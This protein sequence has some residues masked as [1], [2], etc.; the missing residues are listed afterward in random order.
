MRRTP[1]PSGSSA[2]SIFRL[3]DSKYFRWWF[4]GAVG[5]ICAALYGSTLSFSF[6]FDDLLYLKDNPFFRD[7][8]SFAFPTH[9]VAFANQA[10]VLGLD[11]DLS[12]NLILRPVTYFTFY[13][14]YIAEG[15][16][17][18]GFRVVNIAIHCTNTILLF[19]LLSHLLQNSRKRHALSAASIH[20]IA[21]I[22]ALLFLVHPMQIESVTYVIQRFTSFATFWFLFTAYTWFRSWS[23]TSRKA[24]LGWRSGAVAGLLLG[25]LTKECLFTAPFML[26]LLDWLVAGTLL[27]T[28][29]R[30]AWPLF[31]C[32]PLIPILIVL[33]SWAQRN[34]NV[35]FGSA[36]RVANPFAPNEYQYHYALTQPQVILTYLRLLLV[37]VGLNVDPDYPISTSI[38]QWRV[39]FSGTAIVSL[40]AGAVIAYRK[41]LSDLRWSLGF[42]GVIWFFLT[43]SISSSVVP[44]P[45]LMAEHRAYLPSIGVFIVLVCFSDWIRVR[46]AKY[47]SLRFVTGIGL[48][49]WILLLGGATISRNRVW[50]SEIVLWSDAC[51]KSPY[52]GRPWLNLGTAYGEAGKLAE[53]AD[54]F[55]KVIELEPI[56]LIAYGNLV[57][58][59]NDRG[60]HRDAVVA[61]LA[62]IK[63][64]PAHLDY[65]LYHNLGTAFY[66][67]GDI[68]N[69]IACN[70][71]SVTS[72]PNYF[73]GH[74][75][76]AGLYLRTNQLELALKHYQLAAQLQSLD[77]TQQKICNQL[78]DIIRQLIRQRASKP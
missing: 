1:P 6:V 72:N 57:K 2:K 32:L 4:M 20:F 54:C 67:L 30:R 75:A 60:R 52:K 55:R 76:L 21:V 48:A 77:A 40:L 62:G 15:M 71:A 8:H 49:I 66:K 31:L 33:T 78:G 74:L 73:G 44:L 59:E 64:A 16:K 19:Q 50:R 51:S 63:F 43:L 23:A 5:V 47:A 7:L 65:L 35:D 25:M 10:K 34:G 53:A 38:L 17:P 68:T 58:I 29:A 3:V 22:T 69:S 41:R 36:L 11:P 45:D 46:L 39:I 18:S 24:A 42:C 14:N 9:F 13:L 61:G 37:P 27:K 12:T 70:Q 56:S 26:V 28:A